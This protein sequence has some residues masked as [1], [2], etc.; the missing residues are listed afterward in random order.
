MANRVVPSTDTVGKTPS[1]TTSTRRIAQL[2]E[3]LAPVSETEQVNTR[4]ELPIEYPISRLQLDSSRH[5]D[6]VRPLKVAVIGV[7][8]L[9]SR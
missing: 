1:T 2:N 4:P 3:H 8:T 7:R 5:I 9:Y 6:D